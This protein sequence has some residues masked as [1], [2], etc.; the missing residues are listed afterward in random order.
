[1]YRCY[2]ILLSFGILVAF[3]VVVYSYWTYFIVN[4]TSLNEEPPSVL[5]IVP[6]AQPIMVNLGSQEIVVQV[7]NRGGSNPI[8]LGMKEGCGKTVCYSWLLNEPVCVRAGETRDF[9]VE[10][11]VKEAVPF[12][13]PLIIYVN[14]GGVYSSLTCMINCVVRE[15]RFSPK[16]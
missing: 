13:F 1:M 15:D 11:K 2:N 6:Q 10:V 3:A 16:E 4:F 8:I 5:K 9:R 7:T 14:D 12:T